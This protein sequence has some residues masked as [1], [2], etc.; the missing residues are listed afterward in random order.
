MVK[1]YKVD[2]GTY[3][4]MAASEADGFEAMLSKYNDQLADAVVAP[5]NPFDTAGGM[6]V[7]STNPA[8]AERAVKPIKPIELVQPAALGGIR[9]PEALAT[10]PAWSKQSYAG[11]KKAV[12]EM[13]IQARA[14]M[15][16]ENQPPGTI[17]TTM[18]N[19]SKEYGAVLGKAPGS[20]LSAGGKVMAGIND[21]N[22]AFGKGVMGGAKSVVDAFGAGSALSRAFD[23]ELKKYDTAYATDAAKDDQKFQQELVAGLGADPSVLD[24]VTTTAQGAL[25]NPGKTVAQG[26]GS[27]VT[28]V[29]GG[30]VGLGRLG[31]AGLSALMGAGAVRGGIYDAV[32]EAPETELM[33]DPV[34]VDIRAKTDEKTARD[35]L[36]ILRQS[37]HEA[38]GKVAFGA[39][40]GGLV[41]TY[42]SVE[43]MAASLGK[44][45]SA[46]ELKK[47]VAE[48][49]AKVIGKAAGKEVITEAPQEAAETALG[50]AGAAQGG[51]TIPMDRGVPEAATQAA[52][53]SVVPGGAAGA[54]HRRQA[55]VQAAPGGQATV[56][57]AM[58]STPPPTGQSTPTAT[59]TQPTVPNT[60]A[61][62][63]ASEY[64]AMGITS[65]DPNEIMLE[66]QG[67]PQRGEMRSVYTVPPA[68]FEAT[69]GATPS[70]LFGD[71]VLD[72]P[73]AGTAA[74]SMTPPFQDPQMQP[75]QAPA[76][77]VNPDGVM[78]AMEEPVA[79]RAGARPDVAPTQLEQVETRKPPDLSQVYM[80]NAEGKPVT[81]AEAQAAQQEAE[82]LIATFIEGD[83][84]LVPER[85]ELDAQSVAVQQLPDTVFTGKFAER[86]NNVFADD[87]IVDAP[88][89][90]AGRAGVSKA[91]VAALE[92]AGFA[93]NGR[94][95]AEQYGEW[96]RVAKARAMRAPAPPTV[97]VP[98]AVAPRRV[99]KKKEPVTETPNDV[100]PASPES[101]RREGQATTGQSDGDTPAVAGPQT[102]AAGRVD[103]GVLEVARARSTAKARGV[104]GRADTKTAGRADAVAEWSEYSDGSVAFDK[105]GARA[106]QAWTDAVNDGRPT[107]HLADELTRD[108][109]ALA[110]QNK[111]ASEASTEAAATARDE[112]RSALAAEVQNT[113]LGRPVPLPA[114]AIA[115]LRAD[116]I[117]GA[118]DVIAQ[119]GSTPL[120][121]A[122]AAR[123][124]EIGLGAVKVR[125]GMP[126]HVPGSGAHGVL[127]GTY[128]P[129]TRTITLHP[130]YGL[131]EHV[132][133]H[134]VA[135]AATI[136]GIDNPKTP[137]QKAAVME[138][139]KLYNE[140]AARIQS[141]KPV[142]GTS[143][144][145]K[146]F[147]GEAYSNPKLQQQLKDMKSPSGQSLW[148][149]VRNT[150]L[151]IMGLDK[152]MGLTGDDNLLGRTLAAADA[153]LAPPDGGLYGTAPLRI[154]DVLNKIAPER[155]KAA[156]NIFR[157][158][159][160]ESW[161]DWVARKLSAYAQP[162][163]TAERGYTVVAK[164]GKE[165]G[166]FADLPTARAVQS[167]NA[168]SVIDERRGMFTAETS[169]GKFTETMAN[170]VAAGTTASLT[171]YVKPF[172]D[173]LNA[174]YKEDGR[175]A[176]AVHK[177]LN[178]VAN[179]LSALDANRVGRAW[180]TALTPT[181]EAQRMSIYERVVLGTL[182]PTTGM[183]MA[184]RIAADPANRALDAQGN[185][186]P[187]YDTMGGITDAAANK[188][189]TDHPEAAK[190]LSQT[191]KPELDAIRDHVK[192]LNKDALQFDARAMRV[193]DM[194][195]QQNYF[196]LRGR[197][198]GGWVDV[199]PGFSPTET[200]SLHL[201]EG[202]K[203]LAETPLD[204][205]IADVH[206]ANERVVEKDR[207]NLLWR[208]FIKMQNGTPQ[209]KA[210]AK[211]FFK[212]AGI[213]YDHSSVLDAT[214]SAKN[215]N[216]PAH[217]SSTTIVARVPARSGNGKVEQKFFVID[218]YYDGGQR[219]ANYV[220]AW[221]G[222]LVQPSD[223][224]ALKGLTAMTRGTSSM[225]TRLNPL[226]APIDLYR[227]HK[228]LASMLAGDFGAAPSIAYAK[229]AAVANPVAIGKVLAGAKNVNPKVATA[230]DE[231]RAEG[232]LLTYHTATGQTGASAKL[233]GAGRFGSQA[234]DA[235]TH[236]LDVYN[237]AYE[238]SPR[239]AAY[240]AL[241]E[242]GVSKAE[243][244]LWALRT[245]NFS[246]QGEWTNNIR[247]VVPFFNPA[248]QGVRRVADVLH[249][250]KIGNR[251]AQLMVGGRMLMAAATYVLANSLIGKDDEGQDELDKMAPSKVY[252]NNYLPNPLTGELVALPRP[253]D[254]GFIDGV[255]IAA[256]R[257]A[258]GHTTAADAV[259]EWVTEGLQ[260][261]SPVEAKEYH[262]VLRSLIAAFSGGFR[263]LYEVSVNET[264]L[265]TPI[266]ND[267]EKA[268]KIAA[269]NGRST[270]PQ[271]YKDIAAA[272]HGGVGVGRYAPEDVRHVIT[273]YGAWFGQ[274]LDSMLSKLD[275]TQ[276]PRRGDSKLLPLV[277]R[278]T[279]SRPETRPRFYNMFER[280]G[281]AAKELNSRPEADRPQWRVDNPEQAQLADMHKETDTALRN[282]SRTQRASG[283]TP[284]D[285]AETTQRA[286]ARIQDDFIRRYR[287]VTQ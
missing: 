166:S 70:E 211:R 20:Q 240:M 174:F 235:A 148:G 35:A 48:G 31:I 215:A 238:Y 185:P 3:E 274:T 71:K 282:L 164:D 150:F 25:R 130:E 224:I 146:E 218:P 78:T 189:L 107:I 58:T 203:G 139:Y 269:L 90:V 255:G 153:L 200:P 163:F 180:K 41:G 195:G 268:G 92:A 123:F 28:T 275:D 45:M 248:A 89:R 56:E 83:T 252:R 65:T 114:E 27:I 57:P 13:L 280:A 243:A 281:E 249:Q 6:T 75:V 155:A 175:S 37:L 207:A 261:L 159:P 202:R 110:V 60:P 129:E 126:E 102:G 103:Q 52:L 87:A 234:K 134:E 216:E 66:V 5:E 84:P 128:N 225:F 59:P 7:P 94:M 158:R 179:A 206:T 170:R 46:A 68:E 73:P 43:Q 4:A 273:N 217:T 23:D 104:R 30:A 223:N 181:A 263:P 229:Y 64:A 140:A 96:S 253:I 247:A 192:Q 15:I 77:G 69:F 176:Y 260:R 79:P 116:N 39:L 14:A 22:N 182:P 67:G 12:D 101:G 42:G 113:T 165:I 286:R 93:T 151:R 138:L 88:L 9:T 36:G 199:P 145:V 257:V 100:T 266:A 106:R 172:T 205:L 18:A 99:G 254:A 47:M 187:I 264:G 50:N 95:T 233:R 17:A 61:A 117:N 237:E 149:R 177:D 33:N 270:T 38:Q 220:S 62:P 272:L 262:G 125:I 194:Y 231:L 32:Q 97:E 63:H 49:Y 156:A 227:T 137:A 196:P 80:V 132:L 120:A 86:M 143:K 278:F 55:G 171:Q 221:S 259:K 54:A 51:A 210:N 53:M 271:A 121:R 119:T 8:Q 10:D 131:D 111:I 109:K 24:R 245:A 168:G 162:M 161:T 1:L 29:A 226:F 204:N 21:I 40:I 186:V 219:G 265:G 188:I 201:R 82:Q 16:R 283:Q 208:M 191:A 277:G 124:R 184:Q 209:E 276:A 133:L 241:R 85:N 112:S 267:A 19:L 136:E 122:I 230:L 256:A 197:E 108:T 34:Y 118:L 190:F 193:L 246:M 26:A 91:D 228:W 183:R 141:D 244:S 142:Y 178:L 152:I 250:V 74:P 157:K 147:V 284:A 127:A 2:A 232:G 173:K 287:E 160:N 213:R 154:T 76:P 167:A 144:G 214:Q 115:A 239:V 198:A 98:A 236:I 251:R 105:L 285:S 81:V 11:R 258:L 44:T 212:Q 279:E 169:P 222:S 72:M 242:H 135:H